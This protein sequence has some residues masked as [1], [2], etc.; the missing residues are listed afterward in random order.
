[1]AINNPVITDSAWLQGIAEAIQG[2]DGGG[3]MYV[4]E[5]RGRIEAWPLS[6]PVFGQ[7][8]NRTA[9]GVI[10]SS[11]VRYLLTQMFC[12][13]EQV[14]GVILNSN[15]LYIGGPPMTRSPERMF[16]DCSNLKFVIMPHLAVENNNSFGGYVFLNCENL[17]LI[18]LNTMGD[19]PSGSVYAGANSVKNFVIP[20][21]IV[22]PLTNTVTFINSA[23]SSGTCSICVPDSL[24]E[25]YKTETNWSVYASQFKGYS[26][27]PD[28]ET[29]VI[30]TI[31]DLCKYDN[32]LYAWINETDGNSTP[33]G[34]IDDH[35]D[36]YC[37]AEIEEGWY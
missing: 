8:V 11:E 28:Y 19:I 31:G 25:N 13:M 1:M 4:T 2:K 20:N 3:K 24:K 9:T 34:E 14:T 7:I 18:V 36:W 32:K 30:Y 35:D 26:E 16:D 10:A 23:I 21:D 6:S 22:I 37:I 12:E 29:D 5:M 33:F 15:P 17:K 27:A